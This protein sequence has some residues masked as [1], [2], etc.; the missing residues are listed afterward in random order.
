[1]VIAVGIYVLSQSITQT[2]LTNSETFFEDAR[3]IGWVG[4]GLLL[5]AGLLR[6]GNWIHKVDRVNFTPQ[7]SVDGH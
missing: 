5:I 6:I 7:N 3:G 1:M 2:L 4:L